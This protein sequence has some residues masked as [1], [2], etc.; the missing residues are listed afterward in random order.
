MT[1]VTAQQAASRLKAASSILILTHTS[2][3]GDTIGSAFGLKH[4]LESLGKEVYVVCD[5]ILPERLQFLADDAP[6]LSPSLLPEHFS[7]DLIVAVD[8]AAL[9]LSGAFGQSLAG[10]IDLRLDHHASGTPY[11]AEE[12]VIG[13]YGSCGE[14]IF[15]ILSL[16][17]ALSAEAAMPIYG[18]ICS[19]TGC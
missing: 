12:C 14:L 5:D 11:A 4:G 8:I 9:S 6:S 17:N 18:A 2:P 7:P 13:N 1:E 19:D 15:D 3:V 16:L 10:K